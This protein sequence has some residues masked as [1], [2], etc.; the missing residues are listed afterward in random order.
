MDLGSGSAVAR[1]QY[2]FASHCV[3][4][5]D[6]M[7]VTALNLIPIGQLDGGHIVF[8]LSPTQHKWIGRL[9]FASIISIG[10]IFGQVGFSG[11]DDSVGGF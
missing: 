7:L 2:S 1:I 5:M 11:G 3:C 10:D 4:G 6:S 9:F 8:A